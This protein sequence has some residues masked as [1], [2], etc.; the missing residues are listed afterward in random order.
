[1]QDLTER[2]FRVLI[3]DRARQV[4]TEALTQVGYREDFEKLASDIRA[5]AQGLPCRPGAESQPE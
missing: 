2:D 5:L 4:E 1:M 3:V